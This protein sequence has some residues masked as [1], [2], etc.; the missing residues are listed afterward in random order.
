MP[1]C[2]G[3]LEA[4]SDALDLDLILVAM[5]NFSQYSLWPFLFC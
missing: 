5:G 2:I 4:G 3:Q 1:G